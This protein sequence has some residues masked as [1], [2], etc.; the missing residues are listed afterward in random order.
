MINTFQKKTLDLIGMAAKTG[1]LSLVN[2]QDKQTG[3]EVALL[4]VIVAEPGGGNYQITPVAQLFERSGDIDRYN[5]PNA[6]GGFLEDEPSFGPDDTTEHRLT[7]AQVLNRL[8]REPVRDR[9]LDMLRGLGQS[10][11]ADR[12]LAILRGLANIVDQVK[13]EMV[14]REVYQNKAKTKGKKKKK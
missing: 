4:S 1:N 14:A 5:P 13:A 7:L 8:T 12:R 9:R 10:V 2:C 6:D 11:D 3:K